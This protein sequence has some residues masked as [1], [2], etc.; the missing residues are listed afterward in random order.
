MDKQIMF[1][2]NTQNS[3]SNDWQ[4]SLNGKYIEKLNI[5]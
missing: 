2:F 4:V 3:A 1:R 5:L